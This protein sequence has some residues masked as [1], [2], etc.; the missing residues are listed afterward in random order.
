MPANHCVPHT[1]EAKRKMSEARKGVPNYAKRR[2]TKGVNGVV[3]YQCG[4]CKQFYPYDGFYKDKRTILGIKSECKKCH[5][6]I[7]ILSRTEST[8]LKANREYMRRARVKNP[9]KFRKRGREN[10]LKRK[11]DPHKEARYLLNAA[12]RKGDMTKPDLCSM[13][14]KRKRITAHHSDY[15]KPY[16]VAWL[17]Y[18]CH[19]SVHADINRNQESRLGTIHNQKEDV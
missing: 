3:Y 14:G 13:C 9:E 1:E 18:E 2:K 6:K 15:S 8:Y 7:S 19:G 11:N 16:D 4:R 17:C 10:S 5:T 12:L